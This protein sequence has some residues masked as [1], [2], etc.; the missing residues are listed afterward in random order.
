MVWVVVYVF[1]TLA[2][3][4]WRHV[5]AAELIGQLGVSRRY[6]TLMPVFYT[7]DLHWCAHIH[8]YMHIHIYK[9][10][11]QN[12]SASAAKPDNLNRVPRVLDGRREPT[13]HMHPVVHPHSL[14][15]PKREKKAQRN[16]CATKSS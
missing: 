14:K 1:I 4:G 6:P 7:M 2:L 3:I 13:P 11:Q 12:S 5:G 9:E 10:G 8:I 15:S 16:V